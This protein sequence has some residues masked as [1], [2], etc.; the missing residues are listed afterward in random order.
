MGVFNWEDHGQGRERKAFAGD[1][2][3][4]SD[5]EIV[6]IRWENDGLPVWMLLSSCD[7]IVGRL[8]P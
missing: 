7:L 3:Q 2:F 8:G 4:R 6:R 1:L 5:E